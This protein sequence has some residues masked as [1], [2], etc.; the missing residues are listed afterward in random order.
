MNVEKI[1]CIKL[2]IYLN[3]IKEWFEYFMIEKEVALEVSDSNADIWK[4]LDTIGVSLEGPWI[5]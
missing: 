1:S 2:K 4:N 3:N 5:F